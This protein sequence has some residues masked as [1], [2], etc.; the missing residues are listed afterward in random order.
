[1]EI[2]KDIEKNLEQWNKI[3][4]RIHEDVERLRRLEKRLAKREG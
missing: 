2:T 4:Q 1:M 3:I